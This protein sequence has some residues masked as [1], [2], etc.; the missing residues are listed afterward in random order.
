MVEILRSLVDLVLIRNW[1][2]RGV[3]ETC[4]G[5]VSG[6]NPDLS[7]LSRHGMVHVGAAGSRRATGAG[8]GH[9]QWKGTKEES[10]RRL[11]YL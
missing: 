8:E 10:N 2:A 1:V 11:Q 6:T 9:S 5:G 7:L 3:D 4:V